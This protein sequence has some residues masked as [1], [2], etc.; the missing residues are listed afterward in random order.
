MR[1]AWCTTDP[2]YIDYHDNEWGVPVHDERTWFEFITLEG[3]QAGLSWITILKKRDA[4]RKAFHNFDPAK[5]AAMTSADVERLM[6]DPGIIRNR[7]KIESAI[8][9]AQAFLKEPFDPFIWDFIG[10]KPI[11]NHWQTQQEVPASTPLSDAL[12]K[13]LK[14]RG[15][16]FVGTTICYAL[17]QATGLVNDHLRMCFKASG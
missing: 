12:S 16:R 4:F 17:M 13:E 5:V 3:M 14:R 15:F 1:C 2:L 9:N 8:T 11:V 10:G 6:Q 7:L